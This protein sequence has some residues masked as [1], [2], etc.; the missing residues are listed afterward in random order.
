MNQSLGAH[1]RQPNASALERLLCHFSWF[2]AQFLAFVDRVVF[3]S[4][5]ISTYKVFNLA[6]YRLNLPPIDGVA[7]DL[8]YRFDWSQQQVS[9]M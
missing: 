4:V 3:S 1:G 9:Y 5:C 7:S 2:Y 6:Y 8:L